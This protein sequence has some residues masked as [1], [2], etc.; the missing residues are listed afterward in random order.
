LG[1]DAVWFD[2]AGSFG[3]PNINFMVIKKQTG[4]SPSGGIMGFSRNKYIGTR[5]PGPL[6][7]Y[8]LDTGH[9]TS[10]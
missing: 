10:S 4:I 9:Y 8:Y 7:Y 6:V 1:N 3:L 2:D 5:K